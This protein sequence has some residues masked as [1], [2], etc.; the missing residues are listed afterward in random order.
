MSAGDLPDLSILRVSEVYNS[1][2]SDVAPLITTMGMSSEVPLVD[3]I[4]GKV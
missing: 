2:S 1:F 4:F 3:S